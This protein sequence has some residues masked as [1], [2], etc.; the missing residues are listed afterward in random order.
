MLLRKCILVSSLDILLLLLDLHYIMYIYQYWKLSF[1]KHLENVLIMQYFNKG[2]TS[3]LIRWKI[4]SLK[5]V[6]CTCIRVLLCQCKD[7][8]VPHHQGFSFSR[9]N[10]P[11]SSKIFYSPVKLYLTHIRFFFPTIVSLKLDKHVSTKSL[12]VLSIYR[13]EPHL[14]LIIYSF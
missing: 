10:G 11:I 5:A 9:S 14:K 12:L 2:N 13:V 6:H 1:G 7:S 8:W 3:K 4:F